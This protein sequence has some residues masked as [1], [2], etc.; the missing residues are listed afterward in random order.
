MT[1]TRR[2]MMGAAGSGASG[3]KLY[4]WGKG[5][6]GALGSGSTTSR[7]TPTQVGTDSDWATLS[8]IKEAMFATK[9]NGT[10]WVWGNG[11]SG[12]LGLGNETH[13]SSPVQLG[14][15]TDWPTEVTSTGFVAV[16]YDNC[17]IVK[18]N[19]TLWSWGSN[20]YGALGIGASDGECS[21]VQVGSLTDWS[22][23]SSMGNHKSVLAIKTN[24]TLWAWGNNNKGQ[25]GLG[26]TTNYSS[27]VQVGSLTNWKEVSVGGESGQGM[28]LASKT[29][30]TFWAWGEG[31]QGYL[32]RGSDKTDRSSPVQTGSLT[33]W[34]HVIAKRNHQ[35]AVKTDGTL[36]SWGAAGSGRSGLGNTTKYS[37]PV[38]VGSLTDWS[39]HDHNYATGFGLKTDGTLWS[40]GSGTN[41]SP[42][43]G[44]TTTYSSPVQ[45]GSATTWITVR[46]DVNSGGVVGALKS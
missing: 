20:N 44:N 34:N 6:N 31:G 1:N 14:S 32:A 13:Y 5:T 23:V 10:M 7:S 3:Y 15:L 45:I 30:G 12:R 2:G 38:Q 40:W 11:G 27:P 17:S 25:L 46:T 24:G 41:G 42:G 35:G 18:P 8:V 16:G 22:T 4:T 26:N 37:S 21:P 39:F 43:H 9:S 33:N 36:W 29:D 19:G 28:T